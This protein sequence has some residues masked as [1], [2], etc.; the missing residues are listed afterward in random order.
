MENQKSAKAPVPVPSNAPYPTAHG[1]FPA[2]AQ[3][4]YYTPYYSPLDPCPPIR[5][6]RYNTPP[7]LFVGFQPMNLPQ[8]RPEEA[9]RRGTLWPIFYAPYPP[10]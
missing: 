4:R 8:F 1:S 9:L 2:S 10:R 3:F 6:R 7:N 5:V